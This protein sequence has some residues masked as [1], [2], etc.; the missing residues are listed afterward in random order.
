MAVTVKQLIEDAMREILALAQGEAADADQINDGKQKLIDMLALWSIEGLMVPYIATETFNLA[1]NT[2]AYTWKPGGAFNS[3]SPA[4]V[5]AASF[6]LG[7]L[8]TPLTRMDPRQWIGIPT[9]G[10]VG[11]PAFYK[12]E[13]FATGPV[14]TVDV[15]P[16]GGAVTILSRKP[17][18][19]STQF[20]LTDELTFS[21]E[22]I[23]PLRTNLAIEIAPG[24]EKMAGPDLR[25]NARN[26]KRILERYNNQPVPTMRSNLPGL[27]GDLG[28]PL[29]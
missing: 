7:N 15:A 9:L 27:S 12:F 13:N 18:D 5:I 16:Y 3:V 26:G 8:Q 10:N 11:A 23:Q 25:L 24:F 4:D 1:N 20:E 28:L 21:P 6:V 2:S 17:F 14:F 22:Y 19:T 29:R